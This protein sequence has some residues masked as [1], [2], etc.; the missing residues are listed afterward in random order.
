MGPMIGDYE[1]QSLTNITLMRLTNE[2][3]VC[4]LAVVDTLLSVNPEPRQLGE[5]FFSSSGCC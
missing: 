1:T 4:G 5:T 3:D 2:G